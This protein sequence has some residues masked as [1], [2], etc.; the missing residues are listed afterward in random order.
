[1]GGVWRKDDP[2]DTAGLHRDVGIGLAIDGDFFD[3]DIMDE[4]TTGF[5]INWAVQVGPVSHTS[6]WTVNFIRAY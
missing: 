5:R 4:Y 3:T 6:R 2:V 1:V